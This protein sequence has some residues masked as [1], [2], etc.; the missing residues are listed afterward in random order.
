M[1]YT[2]PPPRISIY[3]VQP[4]PQKPA[5]KRF[6][7][8]RP[9]QRKPR[10]VIRRARPRAALQPRCTVLAARL[11]GGKCATLPTPPL[12]NLRILRETRLARQTDARQNC[13][14][15]TRILPLHSAAD[16][17]RH[18]I[19]ALGIRGARPENPLISGRPATR[20]ERPSRARRASP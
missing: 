17:H 13:V 5:R 20:A 10:R 7:S 3:F 8:S 6:L 15:F 18:A 2:A 14:R 12:Q 9:T 11:S 16:A 1:R 4:A 19:H